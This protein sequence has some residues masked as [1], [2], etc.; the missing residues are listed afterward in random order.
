MSQR[1]LSHTDIDVFWCE[2]VHGAWR[3][4][5]R[6]KLNAEEA[7]RRCASH[8]NASQDDVDILKEAHCIE[9][10]A[11]QEYM[12]VLRVFHELVLEGKLP[13]DE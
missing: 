4:Y 10:L 3:E 5:S 7:L 1:L 9:D 6:A 13:R 11:L 12:R 8:E 2:R